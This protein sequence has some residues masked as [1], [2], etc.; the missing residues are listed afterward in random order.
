M[1]VTLIVI[2]AIVVLAIIAVFVKMFPEM[3]RYARMRSM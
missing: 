2:A 3:R 1:R